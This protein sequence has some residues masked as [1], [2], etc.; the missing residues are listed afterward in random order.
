MLRR[1][2]FLALPLWAVAAQVGSAQTRAVPHIAFLGNSTA[3]LEANLVGPF[4]D[5]LRSLGYVEGQTIQIDDRWAEGDYSRFPALV[6]ELIA[7]NPAVIVTAGTPAAT[8]LAS[9]SKTIPCV[10]VAVGD[11]VGTGLIKSLPHPGGNLTGLTSIAP[12]LEGK[13]L[14]LLREVIPTLSRVAVF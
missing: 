8:A 1:T 2:F 12:E 5:G 9:A 6:Q 3:A 14:A 4:R 13:R 10:M 11:P 7:L